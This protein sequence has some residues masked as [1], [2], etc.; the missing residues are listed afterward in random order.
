MNKS[1]AVL[2]FL[3]AFLP[4]FA[5]VD[6]YIDNITDALD[7][8]NTMHI[9]YVREISASGQK[10]IMKIDMLDDFVNLRKH[11]KI[12]DSGGFITDIVIVNDTMF[13]PIQEKTYF[14]DI[15]DRDMFK[16][17]FNFNIFGLLTFISA[18]RDNSQH[19][20]SVDKNGNSLAKFTFPEGG[21]YSKMLVR[22]DKTGNADLVEAYDEDK[23]VF[24]TYLKAY[25]DGFPYNIKTFS[26]LG[27][28]VL[29]EN[30]RINSMSVNCPADD[31]LFTVN[32]GNE[33]VPVDDM[34][35]L[36]GAGITQ[37]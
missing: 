8:V 19:K 24:Q 36:M 30:I 17:M 23:V 26:K 33:M 3:T 22:F 1:A 29:E 18:V 35:N 11:V 7:T 12:E 16:K 32:R 15:N 21:S 13:I 4:L 9:G 27:E 5:D 20:Y 28:A 2:L 10:E 25:K 31:S 34:L 6:L 37:W 14:F